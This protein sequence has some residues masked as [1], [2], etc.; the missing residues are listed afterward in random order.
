MYFWLEKMVGPFKGFFLT[1]QATLPHF[2][3]KGRR[4]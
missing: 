2:I 3:L 4:E 1:K